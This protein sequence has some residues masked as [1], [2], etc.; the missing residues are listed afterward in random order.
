ME[1]IRN[2]FI[3]E[4]QTEWPTTLMEWDALDKDRT[5]YFGGQIRDDHYSGIVSI[6]NLANDCNVPSVLPAAFYWL[7]SLITRYGYCPDRVLPLLAHNDIQRLVV[8][9]RAINQLLLKTSSLEMGIMEWRCQDSESPCESCH[10]EVA[11]WWVGLL[12]ELRQ[13]PLESLKFAIE[14]ITPGSGTLFPIGNPCRKVLAERLDLL[15]KT[16][17]GN[18]RIYFSLA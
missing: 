14:E 6:I 18:L 2:A 8:G 3:Q 17:F 5:M 13:C 4:L 16:L 11:L 1:N 12:D 7:F 9:G 10:L 15:R